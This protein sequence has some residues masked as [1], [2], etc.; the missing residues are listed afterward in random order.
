MSDSKDSKD[1]GGNK[2]FGPWSEQT[3]SAGRKYYY[4]KITEVSQWEK[5][6]EWKEH[7]V[8]IEAERLAAAA[9]KQQQ[10]FQA[11]IPPPPGM[12]MPPP[13]PFF[14]FPPFGQAFPMD[15]P[16]PPPPFPG[17]FPPF[18]QVPPPPPGMYP[19]STGTTS[20]SAIYPPVVPP[21]PGYTSAT[22]A[23]TPYIASPYPPPPPQAPA[24]SCSSSKPMTPASAPTT[25]AAMLRATAPPPPSAPAPAAQ[26]STPH[27]ATAS[28]RMTI[29]QSSSNVSTPVTTGANNGHYHHS[30]QTST[31]TSHQAHSLSYQ[32]QSSSSR[33]ASLNQPSSHSRDRN[34][35]NRDNRDHSYRR[36]VDEPS[37]DRPSS[38]G[39]N[40]H[41]SSSRRTYDDRER[42]SLS[43]VH[44]SSAANSQ[45]IRRPSPSVDS[46]PPAK[47]AKEESP[48]NEEWK[49]F[50]RADLAQALKRKLGLIEDKELAELNVQSLAT[51][52]K[53]VAEMIKAKTAAALVSVQTHEVSLCEEKCTGLRKASFKKFKETIRRME[54]IL[55]V[56]EPQNFMPLLSDK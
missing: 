48:V 20:M 46:Q 51:E 41:H 30:Q 54:Q 7:D 49:R 16:G 12:F 15:F 10:S 4:N 3:S 36:S 40:H 21:P 53:L 34:R 22:T 38:A 50:Y 6:K 27:S 11:P 28:P 39:S 24:V 52:N 8:K 2:E 5:P 33:G 13:P 43:R 32:N 35:D 37:N 47:K 42:G 19:T 26:S 17:A 23:P 29:H 9:A 1:T 55:S 31:P 45:S 25:S 44:S 56:K 14:P 18:P